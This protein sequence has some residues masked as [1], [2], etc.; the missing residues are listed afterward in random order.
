MDSGKLLDLAVKGSAMLNSVR[1]INKA[2]NT[3]R[4]FSY[5]ALGIVI[6]FNVIGVINAI[7]Q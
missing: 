2:M 5:T 7:K 6:I 3:Y 1:K 4:M